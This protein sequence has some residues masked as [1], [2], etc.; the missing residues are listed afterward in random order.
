MRSAVHTVLCWL[1]FAIPLLLCACHGQQRQQMLALLDEADSLNRAYAQLPSDTLL[2]E[3]ADFFD[4]HGSANDRLRAHYLLG[5]A[6]RDMGDAPRAIDC[7]LDAVACADTTDENCDFHRLG[8][9]YSQMGDQFHKQLLFTN[10]IECDW[11]A[12]RLFQKANDSIN[13]MLHLRMIAGCYIILNRK[14]SAEALLHK[15]LY[16]YEQAGL[17]QEALQ[18]STM[19]M[20]LLLEDSLRQ[21]ETRRLIEQYEKESDRFGKNHEL[22]GRDRLFYYYK[23]KYYE[24][25][26]QLDSAEHYYR[27]VCLGGLSITDKDPMYRGLLSVFIKQHNLDSIGK[28]AQLYCAANDSSIAIKDQELTARMGASYN[29]SRF[30]KEAMEKAEEARET[31]LYN[32]GLLL[33]LL[34]VFATTFY[35]VRVFNARRRREAEAFTQTLSRLSEVRD[36]L[37]RL[38]AKDYESIISEKEREIEELSKQVSTFKGFHQHATEEA[39]LE[40]LSKCAI[41]ELFLK[42]SKF[43]KDDTLP[44]DKEWDELE[45]AFCRFLP[46]IYA[47]LKSLSTLQRHVCMLLILD[48]DESIIATLKSIKPQSVNTAKVRA[49]S[50]LFKTANASTLK[51]NLKSMVIS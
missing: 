17:K 32:R 13:T 23:G 10:E 16:Q 45:H 20:H 11:Q 36:E 34:A 22:Q 41:A 44:S 26:G 43:K 8:C 40:K 39:A 47:S 30:Q 48:Y 25:E 28:Y 50:T 49:N 51:A 5:C 1:G 42:K 21:P 15:V 33:L 4:R 37:S 14:D 7:Y 24:N 27:K 38:K 29:Y 9:V 12:L 35:I 19:L 18:A 3:A 2:L 6:Y 31:A 46:A